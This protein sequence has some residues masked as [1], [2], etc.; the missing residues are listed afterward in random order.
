MSKGKR[1]PA[2]GLMRPNIVLYGEPHPGADLIGSA[3]TKDINRKPDLLIVCGTSLK[4][5]GI[6]KLV[7]DMGK[8]VREKGGKIL[9]VNKSELASSEWDSVFDW[10]VQADTDEWVND[11]KKRR[12]DMFMH[13]TR[14]PLMPVTKSVNIRPSQ[15]KGLKEERGAGEA[16]DIVLVS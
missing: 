16:G 11:L 2:V 15:R 3:I 5:V 8:A 12:P 14:L 1:R 13:Q 10:H 7:K 4:V 6:K 9:L